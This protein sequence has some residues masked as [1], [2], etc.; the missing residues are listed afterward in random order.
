M[1]ERIL[2]ESPVPTNIDKVKVMDEF[3]KGIMKDKKK[4]NEILLDS[5][6]EKVQKK[7][8]DIFGPL[9]RMWDYLENVVKTPSDE[10]ESVSVNLEG[11]L[12]Y[13][14]QT[15]LVLGQALNTVSYRRK[16]NALSVLMSPNEA[17]TNIRGEGD[18]LGKKDILLGNE[19]REQFMKNKGAKR[20]TLATLP[21]STS[22][23]RNYQPFRLRQFHRG[24]GGGPSRY[25]YNRKQ[26]QVG[27]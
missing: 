27:R 9:A 17:K 3:F 7:T 10:G 20:K 6:L 5:I 21:H 12:S 4:S 1:K 22:T 24:F 16:Y 2:T 26:H 8:R 23:S 19:F 15:V 25:V 18:L 14:Q 13:T 11:L